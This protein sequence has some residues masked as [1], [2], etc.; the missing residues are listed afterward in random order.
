MS[1]VFQELDDVADSLTTADIRIRSGA[2]TATA[3]Q[4]ISDLYQSMRF[5]LFSGIQSVI[6]KLLPEVAKD[7]GATRQALFAMFTSQVID[8]R[9]YKNIS[10]EFDRALLTNPEWLKFHDIEWELNPKFDIAGYKFPTTPGTRPFSEDEFMD[11]LFIAL[12]R[13]LQTE[14]IKLGFSFSLGIQS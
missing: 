4:F 12:M 2:Y 11:E 8:F 14:W 10:I 3:D 13:Q 6:D 1:E 9:G 7:T 5:M